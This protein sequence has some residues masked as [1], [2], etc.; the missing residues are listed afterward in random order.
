MKEKF[1]Q[2]KSMPLSSGTASALLSVPG[3]SL[4]N[5]LGKLKWLRIE[6]VSKYQVIEYDL[7]LRADY[8]ILHTKEARNGDIPYIWILGNTKII[9]RKAG[10]Q[11]CSRKVTG[12]EVQPRLQ[13]L[14]TL[15]FQSSFGCDNITL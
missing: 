10:K 14:P 3:P 7:L 13:Q 8:C 12:S 15:K 5:I 1:R 2:L 4:S 11:T 9:E 6:E